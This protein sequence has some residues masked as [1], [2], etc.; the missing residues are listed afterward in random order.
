M[1]VASIRVLR[2]GLGLT[3]CAH[4]LRVR[5]RRSVVSWH[6]DGALCGLSVG[7]VAFALSA[8]AAQQGAAAQTVQLPQV[9]V[10]ASR[11]ATGITGAS[12]TVITAED[13]APLAGAGRLPDILAQQAGVQTQH[14][15]GGDERDG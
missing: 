14:L 10:T 8:L 7:G 3:R 11:L 5:K 9:D 1:R 12:T 2:I 6:G 13:I 15:Y 4:A